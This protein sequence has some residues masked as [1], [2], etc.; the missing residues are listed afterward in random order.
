MSELH[1]RP[2]EGGSYI[3]QKDG[4]LKRS[5]ET[6]TPAPAEAAPAE[7]SVARSSTKKAKE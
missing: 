3:R 4:T 6:T 1:E 7:K 5:G 2:R